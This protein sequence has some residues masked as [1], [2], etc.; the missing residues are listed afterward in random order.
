MQKKQ[1]VAHVVDQGGVL[2]ALCQY[3]YQFQTIPSETTPVAPATRA[4]VM[5]ISSL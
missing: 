3:R 5:G 2:I 1:V 4:N